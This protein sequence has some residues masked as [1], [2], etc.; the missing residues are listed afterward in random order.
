[1][2]GGSSRR[3]PCRFRGSVLRVEAKDRKL[4]QTSWFSIGISIDLEYWFEPSR[5]LS[6]F[7]LKLF[8]NF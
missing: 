2:S 8:T 6:R 7:R 5:E 3:T 4:L 1:M